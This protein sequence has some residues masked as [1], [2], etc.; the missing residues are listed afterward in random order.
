MPYTLNGQPA[1]IDQEPLDQDGTVYVPLKHVVE[2]LGG[3]V[4]WDNTTKTASAKVAT[5]NAVFKLG[6]ENI[7]VNGTQVQFTAP[8]LD[9]DGQVWVPAQFFHNAYGYKVEATGANVSIGL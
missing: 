8:P 3:S 6:D 2:A 5:W 7:D 9:E 4:T 1:T